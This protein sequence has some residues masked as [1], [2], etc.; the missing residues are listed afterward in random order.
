MDSFPRAVRRPAPAG[1]AG[2]F[3]DGTVE[4]ESVVVW[5]QVILPR[6]PP[7]M[8]RL[9]GELAEPDFNLLSCREAALLAEEHESGYRAYWHCNFAPVAHDTFAPLRLLKRL[10]GAKFDILRYESAAQG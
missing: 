3:A 5:I 8:N 1:N 7:N 10:A 9:L 4:R 2:L 6:R